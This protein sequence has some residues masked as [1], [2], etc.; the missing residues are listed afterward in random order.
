MLHYVEL[1]ENNLPKKTL[2]NPPKPIMCKIVKE[3]M[4]V[5]FLDICY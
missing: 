3:F 1:L 4:F 2:E 5:L